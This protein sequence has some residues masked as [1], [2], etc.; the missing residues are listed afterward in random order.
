MHR[1]LSTS[2]AHLEQNVAARDLVLTSDEMEDLDAITAAPP[3]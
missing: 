2:L 3:G 1:R